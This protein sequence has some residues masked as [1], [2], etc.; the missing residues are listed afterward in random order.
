MS[1]FLLLLSFQAILSQL[2]NCDDSGQMKQ[3]FIPRQHIPPEE[4]RDIFMYTY[5]CIHVC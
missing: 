1:A 2:T 4:V 3:I 5:I